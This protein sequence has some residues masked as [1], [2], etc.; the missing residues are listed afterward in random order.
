MGSG[1]AAGRS[2]RGP[3]TRTAR[4]PPSP[5][6]WL[7]GDVASAPLCCG[8]TPAFPCPAEVRSGDLAAPLPLD[9]GDKITFTITEGAD[10]TDGRIS[11]GGGGRGM[12]QRKWDTMGFGG[13]R[14][15]GSSHC[16]PSLLLAP[17][18]LHSEPAASGSGGMAGG[19]KQHP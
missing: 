1:T 10:G 13:A 16:R 6:W 11:G 19:Q 8:L 5:A 4:L 17:H 14:C 18:A 12:A 3:I 9:A 7:V 15:R 2:S